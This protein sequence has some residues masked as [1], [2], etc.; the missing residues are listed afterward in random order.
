[1]NGWNAGLL[2]LAAFLWG[3]GPRSF[4]A[5]VPPLVGEKQHWQCDEWAGMP[6]Y[7][8]FSKPLGE[9]DGVGTVEQPSGLWTRSFGNG[10]ASVTVDL[11]G[12][13]SSACIRWADGSV[14][15]SCG[16]TDS[17]L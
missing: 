10:A 2:K 12:K 5:D 9:P 16:K 3:A 1:M 15:G 8:E 11:R 13:K 14:S 4:Y 7:A 17:Q 6:K